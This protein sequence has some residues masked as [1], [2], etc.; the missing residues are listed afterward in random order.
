[1]N[2]NYLKHYGVLGMRWG[3]RRP[4]TLASKSKKN[5]R[6]SSHEPIRDDY[7][8]AHNKKNV[9]YM[10]DAELRSRVNRL[11]MEQQY[12]SLSKRDKKIGS[13]IVTE[14]LVKSGKQAVSNYTSK[15]MAKGVDVL[16]DIVKDSVK[17]R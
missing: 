7:S 2:K 15:Y 4:H 13:K 17:K 1:M 16:G 12:S 11:Q 5:K 6:L 9:K 3:V 10:S 8:K 14:I